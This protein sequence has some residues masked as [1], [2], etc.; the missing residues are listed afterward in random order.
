M[1]LTLSIGIAV[2]LI[3][4]VTSAASRSAEPARASMVAVVPEFLVPTSGGRLPLNVDTL[5]VA[6]PLTGE[7][8]QVPVTMRYRSYD[9]RV[10]E[11]RN[12]TTSSRT[13]KM[14][15]YE[16][17]STGLFSW[18]IWSP[19]VFGLFT[20]VRGDGPERFIGWAVAGGVMFAPL[21]SPVPSVLAFHE[22]FAGGNDRAAAFVPV[23][24]LLPQASLWGVNAFYSDIHIVRIQK[25][26]DDFYTVVV[27][28]PS[29][30][31]YTLVG[32]DAEW[33]L[34]GGPKMRKTETDRD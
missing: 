34:A 4:L 9:Y 21:E 16:L 7:T 20:V 25:G 24:R 2:L 12:G 10:R 18:A 31:E 29:G 19:R 14:T 15:C 26:K 11:F 17:D 22:A 1:K 32:R 13:G 3:V 33:R 27:A 30:D 23:D 28:A 8:E 6:N 5:S